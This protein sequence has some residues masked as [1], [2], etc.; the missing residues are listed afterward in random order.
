MSFTI[1]LR[2]SGGNKKFNGIASALVVQYKP[3]LFI[4]GYRSDDFFNSIFENDN[5]DILVADIDGTEDLKLVV[6]IN[7]C[8]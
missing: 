1:A 6:R 3:E 8:Y 2:L 4:I 7:D 5:Q